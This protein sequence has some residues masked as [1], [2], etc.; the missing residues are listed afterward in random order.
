MR[1]RA[2]RLGALAIALATARTAWAHDVGLSQSDFTFEGGAVRA[3]IVL[4]APDLSGLLDVDRDGRV[5]IAEVDAGA[6]SLAI[7][8]TRDTE[9][10]A[11]GAPCPGTLEQI[12]IEGVDG[13]ALDVTYACP[14]DAS[15]E[16][17]V[18]MHWLGARPPGHRHVARLVAGKRTMSAVLTAE[19]QGTSIELERGASAAP[20]PTGA[21]DL[22]WWWIVA[23]V[24]GAATIALLALRKLRYNRRP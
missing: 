13:V 8:A 14:R 10:T 1:R 18:V 16:L 11:G 20:A 12:R 2:L 5:T 19:R 17:A 6:A 7:L 4:A 22:S 9:V 24:A 21:R 23:P 15:G 3:H